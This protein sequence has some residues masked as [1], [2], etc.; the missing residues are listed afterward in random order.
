MIRIF[1]RR[2]LLFAAL[3]M[4]AG[5]GLVL[6]GYYDD[7]SLA[8][9]LIMLMLCLTTMLAFVAEFLGAKAGL[10]KRFTNFMSKNK[11]LWLL[12]LTTYVIG[13]LLCDAKLR[14]FED[15]L[16]T[17]TQ[18]YVVGTVASI[19][20]YS[21]VSYVMLQNLTIK[22]DETERKLSGKARLQMRGEVAGE[23]QK[24][25]TIGF[26]ANKFVSKF[27][28]V[29]KLNSYE[30]VKNIHY[31]GTA[32]IGSGNS[33]EYISSK[34]SAADAVHNEVL[35]HLVDQMPQE[36]AY[37]SYSVLFG[38]SDYLS[39]M[40]NTSFKISGVMHIVAVSG[41][42]VVFIISIILM[43]LRFIKR[44]KLLKFCI[45]TA[46]LVFYCYLCDYTPSVVRATIMGLVVL[47]AKN[48][49]R[50]CDIL[51]SLGFS[52]I[53]IMFI[54]PMSILDAGFLMSF[55]CVVGIVFFCD[56]LTNFFKKYCKLPKWLAT[57]MAMTISSQIGIYP[58][59]AE[60]FNCFSIY[61]I[62]ANI[63]VVPV[64]SLA[65]ILLFASLLIVLIFPF[66]AFTL[67]F[68]AVPMAFV[69]W[70]PSL[71]VGLPLASVYVFEMGWL[72]VL[73]YIAMVLIS[74]FI[75]IHPDYRLGVSVFL[76]TCI[77]AVLVLS[78]VP[79]T[80]KEDTITELI[81]GC[82]IITTNCNEKIL[83]GVA[84]RNSAENYVETIQRKRINTLNAVIV[85]DSTD[86][87][88]SRSA[89]EFLQSKLTIKQIVVDESVE[90]AY[91]S[92]E[93]K[94]QNGV[95]TISS[96]GISYYGA[97]LSKLYHGNNYLMT[98]LDLDDFSI[99]VLPDNLTELDLLYARNILTANA[100]LYYDDDSYS[101][102]LTSYKR[103]NT[104][105]I[106]EW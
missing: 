14:S 82:Y 25:Q 96:Q 88:D 91:K 58:I 36:I 75:F 11:F 16:D 32:T 92:M 71:F 52:C 57:G 51:S 83:F 62:L 89:I 81:D 59:M 43:C 97:T 42:N 64:F 86:P 95:A 69:Y 48:I 5:A 30:L 4:C 77:I 60:Y 68:A 85:Y 54:W 79:K 53:L 21:T 65:Y 80:Y 66:M 34:K 103:L 72:T 44:Q 104:T 2:P 19:D 87:Y 29:E 61:S 6:T 33:I 18:Y 56:P 94:P 76:T 67:K 105:P 7:N 55:A 47:S 98:V 74:S 99:V 78:N 100:Y 46:V 23:I 102:I 38:D 50:Q 22:F 84:G 20:E 49:G 63:V 101:K 8:F 12:L 39:E 10:S 26:T 15:V 40:T 31:T 1:A 28:S 3:S 13:G 73:Y 17:D 45:I 106:E 37:L 90:Y 27:Q 9:I 93:N 35:E 24:G 41:M 70:F